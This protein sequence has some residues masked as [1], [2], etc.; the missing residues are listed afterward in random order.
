MDLEAVDAVY[1]DQGDVVMPTKFA[2]G[3]WDPRFQHGG[4][5]AALLARAFERNGG[6]ADS[7]IA[8]LG[9]E[10]MRPVPLVP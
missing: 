10:L 2:A 9:V 3:T 6:L 4:A 8:R 5:P 7:H 1:V